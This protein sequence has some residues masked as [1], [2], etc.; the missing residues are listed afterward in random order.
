[1]KVEV[2]INNSADPRARYVTWAPS[3]CKVR[4]SDPTGATQPVQVKLSNK[5]AANGGVVVFSAAGDFVPKATLTLTLPLD[6]S[7]VAFQVAGQF[8]KA[9]SADRDTAIEAQVGTEV[10]GRVEL[11]VR[12]RKDA[13][14]LSPAERNLFIDTFAKLNNQGTGRFAD[15]ALMHTEEASRHTHGG[16]GFLP[17]HRAYLLDLERELQVIEPSVALPY[18]R[19]DKAAPNLFTP[20]FMGQ[21]D[22]LGTVTF[23]PTN[24]L[25]FWKTEG[26]PGIERLPGFDTENGTPR[27]ILTEEQTVKLG[28]A[29]ATFQAME[30]NPHGR[31]HTAFEGLIDD[32]PTAARDPLFF[33]LH[34]NVDRLWALW[35][36][37]FKGYDP[38]KATSF[39]LRDRRGNPA[40]IG[41]RLPDS[42]WPWNGLT[43]SGRPSDAPGGA[44]AASACVSAPGPQPLVRDVFDYQGLVVASSRQGY[45]YDDVPFA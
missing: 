45:D 33:L 24:P 9:S 40:R 27:D 1:M 19:F 29:Y 21:S 20:E 8:K 16:P 12:I 34:A 10:V 3:P 7:S 26:V 15:F 25:Q 22:E 42:M 38:A 13:N 44:L 36:R 43:G 5:S 18:W 28:D 37:E 4:L 31:A 30:G 23:S 17:W 2:L 35:Q 32:P 11:M 41:H 14:T 39:A 6:G